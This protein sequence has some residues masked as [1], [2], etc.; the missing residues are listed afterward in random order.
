MKGRSGRGG[1]EADVD[2][3][4]QPSEPSPDREPMHGSPSPALLP[5]PSLSTLSCSISFITLSGPRTRAVVQSLDHEGQQWIR[6]GFDTGSRFSSGFCSYRHTAAQI[7]VNPVILAPPLTSKS[8]SSPFF[9]ISI[10]HSHS[11]QRKLRS[12][13]S[14]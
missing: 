5:H 14:D 11:M 4:R 13:R 10:K 8:S 3:S 6:R 1:E 9:I 7:L 12:C 2:T